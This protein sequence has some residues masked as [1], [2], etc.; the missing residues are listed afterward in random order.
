MQE[1]A[2][3]LIEHRKKYKPIIDKAHKFINRQLPIDTSILSDYE[4]SQMDTAEIF[5]DLISSFGKNK[6]YDRLKRDLYDMFLVVDE[7]FGCGYN[8]W[9]EKFIGKQMANAIERYFK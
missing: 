8:P 9:R 2:K 5:A 7:K 1:I 6:N 4:K 3:R